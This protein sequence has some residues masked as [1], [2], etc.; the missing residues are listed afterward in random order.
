MTPPAEHDSQHLLEWDEKL[1]DWVDGAAGATLKVA[2]DQ[3]LEHCACCR[4]RLA[5]LQEL[6]RCLSTALPRPSLDSSFDQKL[7]SQL[8][9]A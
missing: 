9:P 7:L 6:D 2:I 4:Q 1:W 8:T 3:H 5:V